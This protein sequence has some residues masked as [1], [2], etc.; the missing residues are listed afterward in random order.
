MR[1]T[2]L[3]MMMLLL[4]GFTPGGANAQQPAVALRPAAPSTAPA[5][6]PEGEPTAAPGDTAA[7]STPEAAKPPFSPDEITRLKAIHKSLTPREREEMIAFYKDLGIDIEAVLGLKA[8]AA[9]IKSLPDAVRGLDFSRKPAAVLAARTQLG[10]AGSVMPDRSNGEALAKYLHMNVLAGEWASLPL[11]LGF[12]TPDDATAVYS[13]VLRS[14]NDGV[15]NLLPEEVLILGDACPGEIEAWQVDVLGQMLKASVARYGKGPFVAALK[16]GTRLF[17]SGDADM[18]DRTARLLVGAGLAVEAYE[19]LPSLE[20]AVSKGDARVVYAHGRYHVDRGTEARGDEGEKDH[21]KRGWELLAGVSLMSTADMTLRRDAMTR[22]IELLPEM[23]PSEGTAWL[24]R[25]FGSEALG[26]AAMEI[27]A[28]Q[29]LSLRERKSDAVKRAQGVATMKAAVDTMLA[30]P[31]AN[32]EALRVPLRMVTIALADEVDSLVQEKA[33]FKGVPREVAILYRASPSETWLGSIEPSVAIRGYRAAI[34]IATAA[35]EPDVALATLANAARRFPGQG[36]DLADEFLRLWEKRLNPKSRPGE[37]WMDSPFIFYYGQ[38]VPAAPLTRGRQRRNLDRLERLLTTLEGMHLEARRMPSVTSV[39]KACHA[40]TEVFD[41]EQITRVLGNIADLPSPTAAALAEAMRTGLGGDWRNRQVQRSY[42]MSRSAAEIADIVE[43]GYELAIELA[44]RASDGAPESWRNAVLLA[45]LNYDR[46]QFKQTQKK[47]DFTK[48]NEY[49]RLAFAAF[50]RASAQYAALVA[51]GQERDSAGV[52]TQWFSAVLDAGQPTPTDKAGEEQEAALADDQIDRIAKSM[53]TLPD[54]AFERHVGAFATGIV[55]ALGG[56]P[57]EKKPTIVRAAVRIVGDHPAGAPLRGLNELYEDLLRNEIRLRLTIDGPDQVAKGQN[58]GL[59]VTLR[60]TN[61]V[62]RETGGFDK[63]LY[64]DAYVRIGNQ[65]RSVNYQAQVKKA[66]ETAVSDAFTV[67]SLGFFEAMTPSRSVK[68][69]GQSGWQEKP[70][71]Y[72]VLKAKDPSVDRIPAMTFD[73]HFDD[74]TGPVTLPIL[75]NSP[76]IDAT[77]TA[78]LRPMKRL[79]IQQTLDARRLADGTKDRAVTFE[80]FATCDGV[81]PELGDLLDG[82]DGSLAGYSVSPADIEARPSTVVQEDAGRSQ[83]FWYMSQ[84]DDN[85]EYRK[86][87]DDG[88]FRLSTER[89]WLVTFKPSGTAAGREF[90]LPTLRAGIAGDVVSRQYADMDIVPVQGTSVPLTP[91]WSMTAKVLTILVALTALA[92]I[93]WL[94]TRRRRSE[95]SVMQAYAMPARVTPLSAIALLERLS[96]E[97]ASLDDSA[98][99][100]LRDDRVSLEAACFGPDSANRPDEAS[101][102]GV[103]DRWLTA[104][105]R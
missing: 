3:W 32:M 68:E 74:Q 33:E 31:E 85:K 23:P 81:I 9:P 97:A 18:R 55:D 37:E 51:A 53:R 80:V 86:A 28:Q 20:E 38:R 16:T 17:G 52:Y 103:L 47:D 94:I 100:A 61:S 60:Y 88:V 96:R 56:I 99:S 30:R 75:S 42:G 34:S 13:H 2:R 8:A 24:S 35:D 84:N 91:R 4:G 76:P 90:L 65:Y 25:V 89:S 62:D 45:A 5:A 7:T 11:V 29:A 49:R 10:F 93:T 6:Q 48:Y 14:T 87:D 95:S 59:S 79:K 54:E 36:I 57:P 43:T 12:C 98:K 105:N 27:V 26:P 77:G 41:R 22:A 83:R 66:I 58:F 1:T 102:R 69:D 104:A 19:Y 39:F 64:Q 40:R 63:Y 50:E 73:M 82:L 44:Q 67:E 21:L 70:L 46:V 78:S 15:P 71:A 101:L 92:G 72:V